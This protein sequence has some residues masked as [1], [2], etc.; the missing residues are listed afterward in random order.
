MNLGFNLNIGIWESSINWNNC[1]NSNSSVWHTS[2]LKTVMTNSILETKFYNYTQIVDNI[3]QHI[4]TL[5][6]TA[7][8]TI[9]MAP[10]K[11]TEIKW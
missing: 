9:P 8:E 10:V 7:A 11:S 5:Q 1:E 4:K 3:V 2:T 6:L